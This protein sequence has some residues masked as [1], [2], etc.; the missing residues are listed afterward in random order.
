MV[1]TEYGHVGIK[2]YPHHLKGDEVPSLQLASGNISAESFVL[3]SGVELGKPP[4][5]LWGG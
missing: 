3:P 1:I 4:L 2:I 5:V